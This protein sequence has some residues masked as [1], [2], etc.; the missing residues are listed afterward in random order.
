MNRRCLF[1]AITLAVIVAGV[2]ASDSCAGSV[3]LPTTLDKLLPTDSF[4]T[5]AGSNETD[6]YSQFR[7]S[8]SVIPPGTPTVDASEVTVSAFGLGKKESGLE[9][10]AAMFA[11]AGTTVDYSISYVVT[12]SARSL[13][14][15][16]FL[17]V[18]YNLPT[19][20]T[21]TISV[22]ESLFNNSTQA[23]IGSLTLSDPP[24]SPVSDTISFAGV[25]S[26]L[27]KKDILIHGG[28]GG[29]GI[30]IIDQGFSSAGVTRS[31]PEP[32]SLV[33]LGIGMSGFLAFRRFSRKSTV[34][35][36]RS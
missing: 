16:A 33:L 26:I 6:T 18:T 30:S 19:N 31:I 7:F 5:V 15:D 21:G 8:A 12:A 17:G 3:P 32:S 25:Q 28:S 23:G 1:L 9:F 10:S 13:L 4:A 2:G 24:G 22:G 29:A 14:T 36:R 20:S 11:P 34:C 27:V 35:S